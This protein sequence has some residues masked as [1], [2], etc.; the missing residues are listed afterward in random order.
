M[1]DIITAAAYNNGKEGERGEEGEIMLPEATALTNSIEEFILHDCANSLPG[2]GPIFGAPLVGFASAAD[3]LFDEFTREEI[4]GHV[5]RRPR[6][7]LADAVTVIAY[8]LPFREHLRRSNYGGDLPSDEWLHGRFR[9]E[10]FNQ[11]VRRF[12]VSSLQN[13]GGKALAPALEKE[14]VVDYA[15]LT[16][17]WSE[18]HVAYAAGLG[19]FGLNRGLITEKGLAGRFG[20]IITNLAFPATSRLYDKIFQYCPYLMEGTCG[21]CIERCPAGAITQRGKDKAACYQYMFIEDHLRQRREQFGYEHSI[22]GKCQVGVPC[23]G[24]IP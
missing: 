14:L 15:A 5:F 6:E 20:S 4:I 13:L 16:S 11:Q 8:F 12:L 2:E 17:N 21:V 18:R 22:C 10:E 7:W 19:T 1:G 9:G 3:P 23:E 24:G